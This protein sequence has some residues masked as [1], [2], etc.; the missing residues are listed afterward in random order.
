MKKM[1]NILSLK[2]N[3]WKSVLII[4]ATSLILSSLYLIYDS[5][6]FGKITF[7]GK[8]NLFTRSVSA[9]EIYPFFDCPCCDKGVEDC[10]C[11]MADERRSFIDNLSDEKKSKDEIF[12]AFVKKY[13]ADSF[14]DENKQKEFRQKLIDEAPAE[15]PIIV[16]TPSRKELGNI[17]QKNGVVTTFFDIKNNG[18]KPLII[19]KMETSCGCTSASIIYQ[20]KEGLKFG[21][22][23]GQEIPKLKISILPG[24]SAKLKVYYDPSFHKNFQGYAIRTISISSNDPINF[25]TK[26]QIDF[27]QVN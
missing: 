10:S 3:F 11:S 15:R 4:T 14:K 8:E 9:E 27:T 1:N 19:N 22:D 13:G 5:G 6:F 24:E 17:S 23:M 26:V 18:K 2:Q 7:N 25:E 21:M 12:L 20:G 16:V